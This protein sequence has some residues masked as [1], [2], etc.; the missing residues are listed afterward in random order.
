MSQ[1]K[2]LLKSQADLLL[3]LLWNISLQG[4]YLSAST[5]FPKKCHVSLVIHEPFS[6]LSSIPS[7]KS[8]EEQSFLLKHFWLEFIQGIIPLPTLSSISAFE[9]ALVLLWVII[10]TRRLVEESFPQPWLIHHPTSFLTLC[11]SISSDELPSW[12]NHIFCIHGSVIKHT[13]WKHHFRI[14]PFTEIRYSESQQ[15]CSW[16]EKSLKSSFALL[17]LKQFQE[18]SI[19]RDLLFWANTLFHVKRQNLSSYSFVVNVGRV[20]ITE[21]PVFS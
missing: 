12:L 17:A 4:F 1:I 19:L 8:S 15:Q 13:W 14:G 21:I 2:T 18:M 16:S 10:G 9:A 20:L 5:A 3:M 6:L 7:N 11:S